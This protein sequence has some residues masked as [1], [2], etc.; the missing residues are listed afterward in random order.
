MTRR[1][2]ILALAL[3]ALSVGSASAASPDRVIHTKSST[4]L[5]LMTAY[6]T[7]LVKKDLPALTALLAPSFQIQ[8]AD[9]SHATRAQ[10]LAK[11]PDLRAF[12]FDDS[13]ATRSGDVITFRALATSTLFING[14]MYSPDPAPQMAVFR[15]RSG[16]WSVVA[17]GNF[18]LPKTS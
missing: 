12:A 2:L 7:L 5:Q 14:A 16:A 13:T 1:I 9:G 11:L 8:R 17:Q 10:Y 4:G 15:W 18:N 3:L 6:S